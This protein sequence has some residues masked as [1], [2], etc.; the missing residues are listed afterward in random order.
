MPAE[1]IPT[2]GSI[3]VGQ[4]AHNAL[5]FFL[6]ESYSSGILHFTHEVNLYYDLIDD[7]WHGDTIDA[8][9]WYDLDEEDIDEIVSEYDLMDVI[10]EY[11]Y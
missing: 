9:G 10:E 3:E 11:R 7:V 4:E 6:D 5:V 8:G 1:I 2:H